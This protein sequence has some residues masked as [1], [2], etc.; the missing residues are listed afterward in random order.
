MS[1]LQHAQCHRFKEYVVRAPDSPV[2]SGVNPQA[3]DAE[4]MAL[5]LSDD[6]EN[7][8]PDLFPIHREMAAIMKVHK[9]TDGHTINEVCEMNES[10]FPIHAMWFET[11]RGFM[12]GTDHRDILQ[13]ANIA[14][15]FG[16]HERWIAVVD[17]GLTDHANQPAWLANHIWTPH[18]PLDT[19]PG[20]Q[21]LHGTFVAGLLRQLA[22]HHGV[23][24]A[25]A[26]PART[27]LWE[28]EDQVQSFPVEPTDELHVAEAILRLADRHDSVDDGM[29]DALNLSFGGKVCGCSD[30]EWTLAIELALDEW[31]RPGN[32]P[33]SCTVFAAAG[34]TNDA[35]EV[36]PAALPGV[37]GVAATPYGV[38]TTV[39]WME[40]SDSEDELGH[41]EN[42]H[43]IVPANHRSWV[44]DAAPGLDVVGLRGDLDGNNNHRL[45]SWS[46]SSFASAAA[47]ACYSSHRQPKQMRGYLWWS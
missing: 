1:H 22:P 30:T 36:F 20:Q 31:R 41:A 15:D 37:R 47:T 34:N 26:K 28:E 17:S 9:L 39:V 4:G 23:S 5:L 13:N 24:M 33:R 11:H 14:D 42:E 32:H 8:D 16:S 43:M 19:D 40:A 6:G 38:N 45:I 27:E 10:V 35:E 46:G 12:T 29:V 2:P 21:P 44:D 7:P 25:R 3:L 18:D